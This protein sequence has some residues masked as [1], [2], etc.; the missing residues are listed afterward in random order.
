MNIFSCPK[1]N[2]FNVSVDV[3]KGTMKC[4]D[5]KEIMKDTKSKTDFYDYSKNLKDKENEAMKK[6]AERGND[7]TIENNTFF[8]LPPKKH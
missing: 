8:H 4:N 6:E 3:A 5:C 1:C 7:I 2:S